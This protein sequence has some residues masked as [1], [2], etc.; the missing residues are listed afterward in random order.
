MTIASTGAG[1]RG[2]GGS[3]DDVKLSSV[4]VSTPGYYVTFTSIVD[5]TL[6]SC[7][8][9][10]FSGIM[11]SSTSGA[12]LRIHFINGSTARSGDSDNISFNAWEYG[13]TRESAETVGKFVNVTGTLVSSL[14]QF[15]ASPG[16]CGSMII[17]AP[18]TAGRAQA[19]G[20]ATGHSAAGG[21]AT[22]FSFA[23]GLNASYLVDGFRL[24]FSAG[25]VSSGTA[26]VFGVKK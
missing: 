25:T 15:A 6:Y 20:F 13:T 16:I 23:G 12:Q 1:G 26:T 8:H 22:R 24:Y 10:Y 3:S 7:Y 14:E 21:F 4:T 11:P 19:I 9:V 5:A 2:S 18:A 17:T